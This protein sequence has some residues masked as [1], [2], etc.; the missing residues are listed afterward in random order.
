MAG[1]LA[2]KLVFVMQYHDN[3]LINK[4]FLNNCRLSICQKLTIFLNG[5]GVFRK[6]GSQTEFI[7]VFINEKT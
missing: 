1:G 4:I 5:N 3:A 6:S 7:K 2:M